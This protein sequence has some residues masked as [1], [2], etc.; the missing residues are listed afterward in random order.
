M[1]ILKFTI[2]VKSDFCQDRG[3]AKKF[4][5][6]VK[7]ILFS[8]SKSYCLLTCDFIDKINKGPSDGVFAFSP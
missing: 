2:E 3:N 4:D 1:H 5:L 7:E 8:L 6:S